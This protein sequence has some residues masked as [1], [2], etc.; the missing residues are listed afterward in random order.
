MLL[1]DVMVDDDI[2]TELVIIESQKAFVLEKLGST[3]ESSEL[4]TIVLQYTQLDPVIQ[5]IAVNNSQALER[6]ADI[7]AVSKA[8][9]MINT[10]NIIAKLNSSQILL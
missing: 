2:K 10:P 3:A 1:N 5:A 8:L 4:Y 9:K 6:S 7:F